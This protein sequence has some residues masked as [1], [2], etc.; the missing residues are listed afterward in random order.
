MGGSVCVCVGGGGEVVSFHFMDFRVPVNR[1][2][3]PQDG[4]LVGLCL[5]VTLCG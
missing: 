5:D 2:R 4:P 1:T 3:S